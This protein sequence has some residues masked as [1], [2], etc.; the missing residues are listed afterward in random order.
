MFRFAQH[1]NLETELGA[2]IKI[3][4]PQQMH[5]KKLRRTMFEC[6]QKMVV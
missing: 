6:S 5:L 2:C 1:D 4:A 3:V